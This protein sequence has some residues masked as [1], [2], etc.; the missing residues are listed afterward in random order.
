VTALA[1]ADLHHA[2][3]VHADIESALPLLRDQRGVLIGVGV[4]LLAASQLATK[5]VSTRWASALGILGGLVIALT[6]VM[7]AIHPL[8]QRG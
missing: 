6:R 4:A 8:G 1:G 2:G 3:I 5:A 7:R